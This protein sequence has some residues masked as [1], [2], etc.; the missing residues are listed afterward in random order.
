VIVTI[1]EATRHFPV[2]SMI[3]SAS[4]REPVDRRLV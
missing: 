1:E 4:D 2:S 3:V